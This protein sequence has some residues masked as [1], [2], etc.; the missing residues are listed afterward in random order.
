MVLGRLKLQRGNV[1]SIWSFKCSF[2]N[3]WPTNRK[4]L[5]LR[6]VVLTNLRLNTPDLC[7]LINNLA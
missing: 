6:R 2:L 4:L 7:L 3:E 1:L 5:T